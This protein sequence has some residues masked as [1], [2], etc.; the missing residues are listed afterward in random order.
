[1]GDV[2]ADKDKDIVIILF[3]RVVVRDFDNI[4]VIINRCRRRIECL[5]WCA[6]A[7]NSDNAANNDDERCE[8]KAHAC[9]HDVCSSTL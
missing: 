8:S 5:C 1:M 6:A 3:S 7:A 4:I 2:V 9:E